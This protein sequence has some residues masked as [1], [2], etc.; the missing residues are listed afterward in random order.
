MRDNL[1]AV[2]PT[3]PP[4]VPTD[5]EE[6]TML[7]ALGE[8]KGFGPQKFRELHES[9]I[10]AAD[11]L[12]QPALVPTSGKR[13]DNLRLGIRKLD[14]KVVSICRV[15]A[16][17]Q[18]TIAAKLGAAILTY[19]HPLYPKILYRSNNAVPVLYARGDLSVLAS[20]RNVACVGSRKIRSPYRER[21]EAFAR[22]AITEGF[23][24]VSGFALGADTLG[25]ETAYKN[26]GK[27]ICVMPGGLDRP[28]PPENKELWNGLLQHS[29]GLFVSEFAFGM[30][31]SALTL[32]KRNRMIVAFAKGVL[33]GQ[34]AKDGGAMNA[35]RF[36][37]EQ[38]KPVA[39]FADDDSPD[40]SGNQ[41]IAKEKQLGDA[42]FRAEADEQ[43]RYEAWL[44]T[45]SSS[46]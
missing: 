34:S 23:V 14:P 40:T 11:A 16:E 29:G 4:V 30:A 18:I 44:Q 33:V 8:V 3:S 6:L 37:R 13:G 46:I 27:T 28:F 17:K 15:R 25:H 5:L 32:R 12:K 24:I 22:M 38:H 35:Y 20:E 31:C 9:G 2:S 26:S 19:R 21:H 45:L 41:L 39:T 1:R 36:S 43:H 42:V 10:S 7:Y